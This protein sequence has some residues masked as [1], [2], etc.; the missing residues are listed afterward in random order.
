MTEGHAAVLYS[1]YNVMVLVCVPELNGPTLCSSLE[2]SIY[3]D[4]IFQAKCLWACRPLH[5]GGRTT[6]RA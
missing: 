6:W 1:G 5:Q 3:I 4:K 2:L